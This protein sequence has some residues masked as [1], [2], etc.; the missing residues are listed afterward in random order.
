ASAG[1][2]AALLI[3]PALGLRPLVASLL[4]AGIAAL[5][6][7][8]FIRRKL[9]GHT[10]DTLGATQQICEIAALCALATAL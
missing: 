10:G 8:A 2:V 3:W 7:T 4:A 5:A 6:F 1:L 9:A